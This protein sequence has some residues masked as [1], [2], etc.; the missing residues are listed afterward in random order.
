MAFESFA[1][2][3][4]GLACVR[5]ERAL[6]EGLSFDAGP[7]LTEIVGPNGAGKSSLL[8]ILAGL[9]APAAGRI[10][11]ARGCRPFDADAE[12]LADHLHLVGH[13]DGHKA[14]M[15]ARENLAFARA[16]F[17]G[18]AQVE[19]ALD[20]LGLGPQADLPVA[21]FSAGQR[22]RL[23]LAR[24]WMLQRPVWLLDEPLSALDAAGRD[25]VR[26]LIA[27]HAAAGG[28]AIAATHDAILDGA[29]RVGVAAPPVR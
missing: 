1:I 11:A 10:E 2:A 16:H 29:A 17:G 9:M 7:G 25:L 28:T 21:W 18:I 20:R 13:L 12:R 19:A 26:A 8:R 6:F 24:L 23:A 15:T 5:G 27:E 22:R 14:A 4:R 3:A